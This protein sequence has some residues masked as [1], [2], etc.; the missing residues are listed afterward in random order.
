MSWAWSLTR[1]EAVYAKAVKDGLRRG[2][3][4]KSL[5]AASIYLA[6]RQTAQVVTYKQVAKTTGEM[7]RSVQ[8]LALLVAGGSLPE[9][10][11]TA[12]VKNGAQRLNLPQIDWP[13]MNV[14][15]IRTDLGVP[16]RAAI[17]LYA[18]AHQ[19]G[20]VVSIDDVATA[21]GINTKTLRFYVGQDGTIKPKAVAV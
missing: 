14:G 19:R 13:S 9:Q 8:K 15:N 3:P 5:Q 7:P 1:A 6:A 21:L 16:L 17:T 4:A 20:W 11:L 10:D 18:G 2:R 12:Y